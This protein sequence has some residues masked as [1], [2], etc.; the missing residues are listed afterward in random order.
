MLG[1]HHE[2]DVNRMSAELLG[3]RARDIASPET[4]A[5]ILGLTD[6]PDDVDAL[7]WEMSDGFD[8]AI[9]RCGALLSAFFAGFRRSV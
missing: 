6:R 1:K 4:A 7:T 8:D 3:Q 5:A 9:E 2:W